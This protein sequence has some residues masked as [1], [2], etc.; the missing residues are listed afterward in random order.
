MRVVTLDVKLHQTAKFESD[1]AKAQMIIAAMPGY[2]GHE[3]HRC[4]E[5]CN[6]YT[7]LVRWTTLAAHTEGF[8]SSAEYQQWK[9]LLHHYYKPFPEVEHY[10]EVVLPVS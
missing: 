5:K 3:L 7:L 1:F 2:L 4:L 6:R 10:E 9:A 8:R